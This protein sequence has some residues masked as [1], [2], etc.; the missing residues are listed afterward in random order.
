MAATGR[1]WLIPLSYP[2]TLPLDA[3]F[4]DKSAPTHCLKSQNTPMGIFHFPSDTFRVY[5][6][7]Y[8]GLPFKARQFC[9]HDK[10]QAHQAIL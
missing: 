3:P 4:A 5:G 2:L 9:R 6:D 8:C 1:E 7:I 10:P